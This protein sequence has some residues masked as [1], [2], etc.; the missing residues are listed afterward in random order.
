MRRRPNYTSAGKRAIKDSDGKIEIKMFLTDPNAPDFLVY[1]S[2]PIPNTITPLGTAPFKGFESS[3]RDG[4]LQTIRTQ[5]VATNQTLTINYQAFSKDAFVGVWKFWNLVGGKYGS[6]FLLSGE[7]FRH[8]VE[9]I[10]LVAPRF[11]T[12][13]KFNQE[14]LSAEVIVSRK[15]QVL[16]I[17]GQPEKVIPGCGIYNLNVEIKSVIR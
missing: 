14:S 16:K 2:D 10:N 1:P 12:F 9:V 15:E 13:W 4:N 8:P 5:F 17:L 11:S 3:F 6:S 7:L